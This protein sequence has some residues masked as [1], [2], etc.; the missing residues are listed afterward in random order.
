MC[1][2]SIMNYNL[3]MVRLVLAK[4]PIR[5]NFLYHKYSN[6]DS[7]KLQTDIFSGDLSSVGVGPIF[8]AG[9]MC[10]KYSGEAL[11]CERKCYQNR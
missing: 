2:C 6:I 5:L 9:N 8:K 7:T 1:K 10:T 4:C 3:N 11:S